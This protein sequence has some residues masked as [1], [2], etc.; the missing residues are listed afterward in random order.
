MEIADRRQL[1]RSAF[2]TVTL[3]FEMRA[4]A[5]P[6]SGRPEGGVVRQQGESP[7]PARCTLWWRRPDKWRDDYHFASGS[8][9][10]SVYNGSSGA[11]YL[12]HPNKLIF[13]EF[14][15]TD[16]EG[17]RLPDLNG[18]IEAIYVVDENFLTDGWEM[19]VGRPTTWLGR[20]ALLVRARPL[21]HEAR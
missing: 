20:E 2:S 8:W 6:L 13:E 18:R 12:S 7:R 1:L 4:N 15:G 19:E 3:S 21:K 9:V 16:S 5:Q 14:L 11:A 10:R 17:R